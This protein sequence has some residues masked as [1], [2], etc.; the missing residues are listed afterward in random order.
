MADIFGYNKST[1][2]TGLANPSNVGV[3]IGNSGEVHLAQSVSIRYGRNVN[4]VFAMGSDSVW[5]QPGPASGSLDISRIVGESSALKGFQHGGPCELTTI[6]VAG[7]GTSDCG[8]SFGTVTATGCMLTNVQ[9]SVNIQGTTVSDGATW[10][11][12]GLIA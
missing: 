1:Q 4:P 2:T 6:T 11:V 8:G 7:T 3:F 12:G 9:V 5:M 10:T